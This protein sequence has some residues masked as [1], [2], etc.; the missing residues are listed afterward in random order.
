V[1]YK[2]NC[3]IEGLCGNGGGEAFAEQL[4]G[5][6]ENEE[7]QAWSQSLPQATEGAKP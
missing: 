3:H 2:R 5:K 6:R 7:R 4:L 1:V